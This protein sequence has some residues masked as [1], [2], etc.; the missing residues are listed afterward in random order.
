MNESTGY[1]K[2]KGMANRNPAMTEVPTHDQLLAAGFDVKT[3][4]YI[5]GEGKEFNPALTNPT[6]MP[7]K[8][9]I[10]F[11][12]GRSQEP[13]GPD[14]FGESDFPEIP[15]GPDK[16]KTDRDSESKNTDSAKIQCDR[17]LKLLPTDDFRRVR[18]GGHVGICKNCEKK[19]RAEARRLVAEG[20]T[21]P[22]SGPKPENGGWI[23]KR[24]ATELVAEAYERG[25]AEGM[26]RAVPQEAEVT[27]DELLGNGG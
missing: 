13:A 22:V 26:K 2:F 4:G 12:C 24:R 6:I 10:L 23:S 7:E 19:K 1:E 14:S 8:L 18:G 11:G 17:C 20:T 16:P 25:I 21:P 3:N 9:A 27:L 15:L 5:T